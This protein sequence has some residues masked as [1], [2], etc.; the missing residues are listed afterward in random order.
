MK[1]FLKLI[2]ISV[3][4]LSLP[5]CD[6]IKYIPPPT[7]A[8]REDYEAGGS[9]RWAF[10]LSKS[11]VEDQ[12]FN[13]TQDLYQIH[14]S[15]LQSNGA[16][17]DNR[18][19][20]IFKYW[21]EPSSTL[22]EVTISNTG[23]VSTRKEPRSSAPGRGVPIPDNWEN[24]TTLF[25][26]VPPFHVDFVDG[27]A[28]IFSDWSSAENETIWVVGCFLS[29]QC[30]VHHV[31]W[32]AR[33]LPPTPP[34][35][36][37][38]VSGNQI[39]TT[40]GNAVI[41]R[42]IAIMDPIILASGENPDLG[43]W[44]ED[45]FRELDNWGA[46]IVRLP[47]HPPMFFSFGEEESLEVIDQAVLWAKKYDLYVIIDFHGIGFPPEEFNLRDWAAASEEEME[48]FW[49]LIS[50]RYRGNSTVAFYE[51]FNEPCTAN[52]MSETSE[53]WT[54]WKNLSERVIDII[55]DND[56][57]T[58][59]LIGGL[60]GG[61]DLSFV[62][63]EPISRPNIAYVSHPYPGT[64][65]WI[66]WENAFGQVSEQYP[67]L[68][69]EFGF[70]NEQD[71]AIF[72]KESSYLGEGIYRDELMT[73]LSDRDIGWTAWVYSHL[74]TPRMLLD[75][76]YTPSEFGLFL[77]EALSTPVENSSY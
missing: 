43:P 7:P 41:L 44:R 62:L 38:S 31:T 30:P 16:L 74:W 18:G 35:P 26:A 19:S 22:L 33:Y 17:P 67:V 48:R 15:P 11:N 29:R 47:I 5:A 3:S 40:E 42:G 77:I 34:L 46:N 12:N 73:Y 71:E 20:W 72:L 9:A 21:D 25:S 75:E 65:R 49:T 37:L 6:Y 59:I 27:A 53:T 61:N 68:I 57:E 1:M 36:E 64:S 39:I 55:R 50:E 70:D 28:T 63:N 69:T 2:I 14:G 8:F 32:D 23:E 54:T 45:I 52:F 4:L 58:I 60:R 10:E 13:P 76:E 56:P 51:L 66:S 24:S